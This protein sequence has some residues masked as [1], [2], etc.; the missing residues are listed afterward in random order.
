[1][2]FRK[3]MND[4]SGQILRRLVVYGVVCAL[5]ILIIVELG[6]LIWDRFDVSQTSDEVASAA[7]NSYSSNHDLGQAVNDAT[8]K[9]RLS[10]L[11]PE[12]IGQCQ[13]LFLPTDASA[14][15]K[16]SVRVTVVEYAHSYL[17]EKIGFLK[18]LAK[19]S[20]TYESGFATH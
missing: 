5:V 16:L 12:E 13:I 3:M 9:L 7:A 6:P 15:Q 18:K 4:E 14:A 11:T 1:M 19:I 2:R 20:S 10:G 8:T 17:L